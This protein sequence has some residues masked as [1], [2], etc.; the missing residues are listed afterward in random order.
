MLAL[1]EYAALHAENARLTEL[2]DAHRIEWRLPTPIA[3][4]IPEPE[5][6]RLSTDMKVALF[7]RL[8]LLILH[9]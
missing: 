1:N 8:S 3:A 9:R 5:S 6:S 4:S 2:L 7:R